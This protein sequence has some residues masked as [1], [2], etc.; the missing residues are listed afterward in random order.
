MEFPEGWERETG[1]LKNITSAREVWI[2]FVTT[3]LVLQPSFKVCLGLIA[4]TSNLA[5]KIQ[6]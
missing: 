4:V 6:D 2:F 5:L 3:K 1:G